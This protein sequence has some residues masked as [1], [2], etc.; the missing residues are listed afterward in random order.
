MEVTK[1]SIIVQTSI[2]EPIYVKP[3]HWTP[4]FALYTMRC[5]AFGGVTTLEDV[6]FS[7]IPVKTG[8][9]ELKID[10]NVHTI[11]A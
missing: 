9:Q 1:G 4:A 10:W 3:H 7:V 5:R 8:I 2:R 6:L 11:M